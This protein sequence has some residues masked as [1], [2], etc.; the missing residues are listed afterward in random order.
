MGTGIST[1]LINNWKYSKNLGMR[2]YSRFFKEVSQLN[3]SIDTA[4]E[5]AIVVVAFAYIF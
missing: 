4:H 1:S 5:T 3:H 2:I